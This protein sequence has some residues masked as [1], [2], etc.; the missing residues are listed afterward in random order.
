MKLSLLRAVDKRVGEF[1]LRALAAPA[2]RLRASFSAKRPFKKRFSFVKMK[3]GGSLIIAMPSLVGLRRA[4]PDVEFVL[5]CTGQVKIYAEL[6]GVFD[7]Y[8]I[9][10]DSWLLALACTGIRALT[11]CFR[12]EVCIDLEPNSVLAAVFAM[13]SCAERRIGMVS[14]RHPKRAIAYDYAVRFDP[15]LPIYRTYD[16]I[17][18]ALKASPASIKDCRA[19]LHKRLPQSQLLRTEG[20]KTVAI[21]PFTSDFARER[22]MP[23]RIWIELLKK[24]Y[25]AAP[26]RLI[27][28]GSANNSFA[29]KEIQGLIQAA[30]PV[31]EVTNCAGECN[32]GQAAA[33]LL[34]CDEL[35]AVDSG[36]LHIARMLGVSTRSFW[37]PTMP[38]QRLRP[39]EGLSECVRYR[40]FACSPCVPY[41]KPPTC[42]G[43]NICMTSLSLDDEELNS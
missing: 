39:M 38:S 10:R 27:I 1:L 36:L 43:K 20:V 32:L 2:K 33:S 13:C 35:W 31:A 23:S 29:A 9:V 24:A 4:Y 16:K 6:T 30:L 34:V 3:G 17:C 14:N 19:V 7:R 40:A 5:A 25:A 41:D 18:E 21:A 8:V 26:V 12:S 15:S 28:L 37:G 42:K 22:M 11:A